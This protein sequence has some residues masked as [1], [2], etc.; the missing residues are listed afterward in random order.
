MKTYTE[1]TQCSLIG[2]TEGIFRVETWM[3]DNCIY[4]CIWLAQ[5][6]S[7]FPTTI[8]YRILI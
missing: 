1:I 3:D 4:E 8:T 7:T 2:Y 5:N 6:D